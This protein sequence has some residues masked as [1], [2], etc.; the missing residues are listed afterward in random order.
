[1]KSSILLTI[2]LLTAHLL[3]ADDATWNLN[4]ATNEWGLATNWTPSTVPYGETAVATF[5]ASNVTDLTV[6]S[7]GQGDSDI[8][9]GGITF[10]SGAGAYT[11]TLT[12][13]ADDQFFPFIEFH[14]AGIT[15]NSGVV[16]NIIAASFSYYDAPRVYF[17]ENS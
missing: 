14:G 8:I 9:L 13:G 17:E 12:Y 2:L 1:M 6:T 7:S 16:Q 11:L 4:P 10:A 15:N 3:C 5:G